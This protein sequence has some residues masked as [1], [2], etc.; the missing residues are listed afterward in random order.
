MNII[1]GKENE[2]IKNNFIYL[3]KDIVEHCQLNQFEENLLKLTNTRNSNYIYTSWKGGI[4]ENK[5][6]L[7][8]FSSITSLLLFLIRLIIESSVVLARRTISLV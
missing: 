2:N 3:S 6:S 1:K 7:F 8:E 4:L 5:E